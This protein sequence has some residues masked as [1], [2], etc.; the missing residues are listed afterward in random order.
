VKKV[1]SAAG[2]A[3]AHAVCGYLEAQGV[4][5]IV[6]GEA[7]WGGRGELA[8]DVN[9]APSVWVTKDEDVQQ[10]RRLI[11]EFRGRGGRSECETCGYDLRGLTDPRCPE[12]GHPFHQPATWTC[13]TC[14]EEIEEQF[15]E[16]WKCGGSPEPA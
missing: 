10:A 16:C 8:F 13:P 2:P 7:L 14:G 11:H 1:Y 4:E 12:C 5:A 9:T 3:E 6:Q 15:A